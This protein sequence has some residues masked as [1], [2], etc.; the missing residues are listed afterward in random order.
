MTKFRK[1][2][3]IFG[4]L[5][6]VICAA[7]GTFVVLSL[8]GS[9]KD[10]PISLEFTVGELY[11]E[12]NGKPQKASKDSEDCFNLV[13]MDGY[14][15]EGHTVDV[16]FTGEQTDVGPCAIGLEVKV[17]NEDG[18]DVTDQYKIKVNKGLLYVGKRPINIKLT[19]SD[20]TYDG[21]SVDI[22]D[23]YTAA[24]LVG[25]H[26]VSL[27]LS[28]EWYN[29]S[30]KV[31]VGKA[32]DARYVECRILDG[33]GN[34]VTA[35]Y[36]RESF[37]GSINILPRPLVI[38]PVSAAKTYDGKPLTVSDYKIESGTL[39]SGH[40]IAGCAFESEDGESSLTNAGSLNVKL[41]A[42][43]IYD[44]NG[45]DV[46]AN[47]AIGNGEGNL[48]V[49]KAPLTITAKSESWVYDGI[50]HSLSVDDKPYSA[51]GLVNGEEVTVKY[52]GSVTDVSTHK[53]IIKECYIGTG[54][55]K[56]YEI[57]C[58]DGT[59][60]VTK[61]PLTVKLKTIEK[62]YGDK[63]FENLEDLYEIESSMSNLYLNSDITYFIKLLENATIGNSTYTLNSVGI[64]TNPTDPNTEITDKFNI[65]VISG[66]LIISKRKV[67]L[68]DGI[69]LS[70]EYDGNYTFTENVTS[71][72]GDNALVNN[73][74]VESVTVDKDGAILSVSLTDAQGNSANGF[75]DITNIAEHKA[76]VDIT[77]R[78]L[79]IKT[80]SLS[81]VYDGLPLYGGEVAAL[82]E[83]PLVY[84]DSIITEPVSVTDCTVSE[85]VNNNAPA[86]K[87]INSTGADIT[88]YYQISEEDKDFGTLTVTKAPLTVT[89]KSYT[90]E[91]GG[92][93]AVDPFDQANYTD[94]GEVSANVKDAENLG[95]MIRNTED[96]ANIFTG[97]TEIDSSEYTF[98]NE[99]IKIFDT[100]KEDVEE[101]CTA[102]FNVTV[103]P[104]T[105]R[106]V[107]RKVT[108][109]AINLT[110]V[111][112][113]NYTFTENLASIFGEDDLVNNDKVESVTVN[114]DGSIY[115]ISLID[116]KGNSA[117]GYYEIT[118]ISEFTANVNLTKRALKISSQSLTK[119]YDG[120]PVGGDLTYGSLAEGDRIEIINPVSVVNCTSGTT[121]NSEFEIYNSNNI[122]VKDCYEL[123][124]NYGKI[125]I[126]QRALTVTMST[127]Y[128]PASVGSGAEQIKAWLSNINLVGY[129]H[130]SG[131]I[132]EEIIEIEVTPDSVENS[133]LTAEVEITLSDNS[134]YITYYSVTTTL[135]PH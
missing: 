97:K 48:T 130:V 52:E 98:T 59:L 34:D 92:E 81:K 45:N 77:P 36:E 18:Y 79:K 7:L 38:S 74:K 120:I 3:L 105:L 42:V 96:F 94:L 87:I 23:K 107:K 14:L 22:G 35:N 50:E 128:Y 1:S 20:V 58:I 9:L 108:L 82:P 102:N 39:A 116:A 4:I 111:Y 24:G 135:I 84:G 126:K 67:S 12:Y 25:G 27:K 11:R 99:Q 131:L 57:T 62:E 103:I 32:I 75:Y 53:N 37:S 83:T 8:T 90:K 86:F 31:I 64:L 69:N 115:S 121:N 85:D 47:Y 43:A 30:D 55:E 117:N 123:K 122:S 93:F 21:N 44:L 109:K 49:N 2:F 100:S 118:N 6:L 54:G 60:T 73:H 68:A 26:R 61:A 41:K 127:I 16:D 76:S 134:N 46:T 65:T 66:N 33:N 70:K 51:L 78:A 10:E 132:S 124:E 88:D 110:K 119:V 29:S 17:V 125:I 91:Y 5:A 80:Q 56:N 101:D 113:G 28:D 40:Y 19:S 71:I 133:T 104:G 95:V 106:V 13:T 114:K 72:F 129:V 89:L 63:T 112:D 15:V